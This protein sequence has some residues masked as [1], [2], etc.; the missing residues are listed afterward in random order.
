MGNT[1]NTLR[2]PVSE[3]GNGP[4]TAHFLLRLCKPR[5]R[6]SGNWVMVAG[7]G[8]GE[9]SRGPWTRGDAGEGMLAEGVEEGV[10]AESTPLVLVRSESPQNPLGPAGEAGAPKAG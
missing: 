10:G 6:P 8:F 9:A 3:Q 1:R 5:A 2:G 7:A 4:G